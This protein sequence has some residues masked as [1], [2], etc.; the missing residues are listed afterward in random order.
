M[1]RISCG[2]VRAQGAGMQTRG[3]WNPKGGLENGVVRMRICEEE[4]IGRLVEK[5]KC[6]KTGISGVLSAG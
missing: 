6:C 3:F 4:A 1:E 2:I 5:C